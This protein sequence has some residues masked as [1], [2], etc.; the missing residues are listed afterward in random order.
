VRLLPAAPEEFR[1]SPE[2]AFSRETKYRN[3][4]LAILV[5]ATMPFTPCF[6][7]EASSRNKPHR[8][9]SARH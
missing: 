9:R 1:F 7:V 4:H 3:A 6:V 2:D 5:I 8:E